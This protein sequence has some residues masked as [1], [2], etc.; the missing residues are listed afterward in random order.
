ME[1]FTVTEDVSKDQ[2]GFNLLDEVK[3]RLM[4]EDIQAAVAAGCSVEIL[5]QETQTGV[6]II[7]RTKEKVS[8][9]RHPD[10]NKIVSIIVDRKV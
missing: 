7:M 5:T 10:N 9:M 6:K 1:K 8:I 3:K 4:T 2:P